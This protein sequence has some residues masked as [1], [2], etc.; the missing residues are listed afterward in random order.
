MIIL[1]V[2]DEELTRTGLIQ[3]IDWKSLG[4]TQVLQAD[5]GQNGWLTA[6]KALPDIILTDVRMPRMNGIEMSEKI[7][8]LKPDCPII[9][10][11][12]YSDKEY[13]KAAIKLRAV[14][15]VE[16]PIDAQEVTEAVSE[17]VLS[18]A[19]RRLHSQSQAL[20]Q[21]EAASQLALRLTKPGFVMSRQELSADG[22]KLAIHS[23][24]WFSTLIIKFSKRLSEFLDTDLSQLLNQLEDLSAKRGFHQI[25]TLKNEEFLILHLFESERPSVYIL[26]CLCKDICLKLESHRQFYIVVGKPVSGPEKVYHSYHSAVILL[27]NA[28]F[29][30]YG[31]ILFFDNA[32]AKRPVLQ[33]QSLPDEFLQLMLNKDTKAAAALADRLYHQLQYNRTLLANQAKDIYYRLLTHLG[34]AAYQLKLSG[35]S[36]TSAAYHLKDVIQTDAESPMELVTKCSNLDELQNLLLEK[37]AHFEK[38]LAESPTENSTVFLIRDYI[39]NH[40]M[41]DRL[42]IKDISE[43]VHLSSSY[44]CTIFKTETGQTLNQYITEYRIEKAKQLLSDPRNKITEISAQVGYADGNYFSKSFKKAVGLS[45]SEYRERELS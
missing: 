41:D 35:P 18:V 40:Y 44:L 26:E 3:S 12:G 38:L 9:F 32:K 14:R 29:Y 25:H 21:K 11:S 7:Q 17:A 2:D 4:I 8:Q 36:L 15:Y 43:H 27:Q 10:M 30:P 22:L 24:T 1:I 28:F 5:D 19:E 34:T 37:I 45:P 42:S 31:S 16:K 6:K 23:S 20:F 13:L 39:G 33:L